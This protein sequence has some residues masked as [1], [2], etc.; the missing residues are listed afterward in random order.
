MKITNIW[1][2][3]SAYQ[4]VAG[5]LRI[6]KEEYSRYLPRDSG[7][8]DIN[9]DNVVIHRGVGP[10]DTTSYQ[11]ANLI[12]KLA[13]NPTEVVGGQMYAPEVRDTQVG[14]SHYTKY[15]IQPFEY[16][17][18]NKLSWPQGEAIK[19]VTRF[20]DKGGEQDLDKAIHILQML[21]AARYGGKE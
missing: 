11:P 7:Q 20:E 18:K 15:A 10:T 13:L 14:G 12:G 17:Y 19:Y 21:K 5:A 3:P 2:S 9:M 1:L 8:I 16:T 6:L 4:E